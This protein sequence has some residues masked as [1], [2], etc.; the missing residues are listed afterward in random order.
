MDTSGSEKEPVT[1]PSQHGYEPSA[2][3]KRRELWRDQQ[4]LAS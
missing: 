3:H 4:V 1:L 2:F